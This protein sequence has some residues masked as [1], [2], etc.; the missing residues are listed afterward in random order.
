METPNASSFHTANLPTLKINKKYFFV[1][2]QS[3]VLQAITTYKYSD[4]ITRTRV[5]TISL[6]YLRENHLV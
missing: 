1:S 2:F 6:D 4:N 3:G 5:S